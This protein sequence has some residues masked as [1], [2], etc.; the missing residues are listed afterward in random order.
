MI[1][2]DRC[3]WHG[4]GTALAR[5]DDVDVDCARRLEHDLQ[6][7]VDAL[8]VAG[9]EALPFGSEGSSDDVDALHPPLKGR[10]GSSNSTRDHLFSCLIFGTQEGEEQGG[11]GAI[12]DETGRFRSDEIRR[13]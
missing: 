11:A 12:P 3:A 2:R 8:L 10:G 9:D 13:L 5:R 4:R 1:F 6:A 7:Q